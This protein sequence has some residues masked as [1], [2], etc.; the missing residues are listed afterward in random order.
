MRTNHQVFRAL[1]QPSRS[2]KRQ[3]TQGQALQGTAEV[4]R[5]FGSSMIAAALLHGAQKPATKK[6]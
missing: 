4:A 1:R 5:G 6:R 3:L 2:A